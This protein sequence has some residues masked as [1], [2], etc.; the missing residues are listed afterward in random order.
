MGED[1]CMTLAL[2]FLLLD[3][4]SQVPRFVV[5]SWWRGHKAGSFLHPVGVQVMLHRGFARVVLKEIEDGRRLVIDD[6]HHG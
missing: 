5:A 6:D 1:A 3:G 2:V 4:G